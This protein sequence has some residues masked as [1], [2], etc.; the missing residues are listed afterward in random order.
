[1]KIAM[2]VSGGQTGA[3]RGGLD[4]GIALGIP[5]GGWCPKNRLAEDGSIPS[6][7]PMK[8]SKT[9]NYLRRTELNVVDSEATVVFTYGPPSGGSSRTVD[10]AIKHTRSFICID[11]NELEKGLATFNTF[12]GKLGEAVVLNVAGSRESKVPGIQASVRDFI[13][14]ASKEN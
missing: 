9:K 1:M 13:I 2:I 14:T 7:Y 8:E 6:I 12:I 5:I 3:D 11:L 4:A 10:F